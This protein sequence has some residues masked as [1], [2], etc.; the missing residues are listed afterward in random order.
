[1][2]LSQNPQALSE[3]LSRD[4]VIIRT[5]ILGIIANVAL[6][7]FKVV[8]GLLS[9]SI[10][11]ILDAVNNLSDAAASVITI[12]GTKLASKNPDRKHPFGYG[13]I[14]YMSAL[15]ISFLVLYAGATSLVESVKKIITPEEP[16]YSPVSL[17]IIGTGVA[18][19]FFLGRYVKHVGKT[20]NS[21][22]LINSGEDASL[23]SIISASTLVA[24]II[25]TL[26]KVSLEAWL[27]AVISLVILKSGLSM[28]KETLSRLLGE[29]ADGK[30]ITEIKTSVRKIEGVL[31]VYDL[32]LNNYGPDT[33]TGSLHIEVDDQ[34][35]AN[36]IDRLMRTVTESV[37]KTHGIYLT[38]ISIYAS[39]DHSENKKKVWEAVKG[40]P[41]ILSMHGF[42]EENDPPYIRFDLVISF[43]SP[44]R[45]KT[46]QE[47]YARVCEAFP[48]YTIHMAM[49]ADF[50]ET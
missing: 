46:W 41:Y 20:V 11:V 7:A 19:K 23:D 1:M 24:A 33:F 44:D 12:V 36:E 27:G 3:E 10:A 30:L 2:S 43:D 5:S 18:V 4:K 31:G 29:R 32:V 47:A 37:Y 21:D 45:S 6:A 39:K 15:I 22:S 49:D 26:T 13:R 8:V 48:G 34:M 16:D 28:L 14:E 9:R 40:V 38:G 35:K 42:Y 17:I 25:F 50:S